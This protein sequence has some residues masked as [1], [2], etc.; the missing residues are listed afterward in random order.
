MGTVDK[1]R[2]FI[3]EV[4]VETRKIAWP[5]WEELRGSTWVVIVAS[6]IITAF[7]AIVD[8]LLNRIL[9]LLVSI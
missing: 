2:T 4:K 9:G 3:G 5:S 6:F 1:L 7:I 8:L